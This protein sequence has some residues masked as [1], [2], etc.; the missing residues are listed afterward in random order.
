[1]ALGEASAAQGVSRPLAG[2]KY[3]IHQRPCSMFRGHEL[4][5]SNARQGLS[6]THPHAFWC[7]TSP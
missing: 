7:E 4:K 3:E 2:A 5:T 6:L 1:M